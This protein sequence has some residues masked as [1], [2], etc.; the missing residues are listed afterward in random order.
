MFDLKDL[1]SDCSDSELNT[2]CLLFTMMEVLKDKGILSEKEIV[3]ISTI[4]AKLAVD[5]IE[6]K[7]ENW[8][9]SYK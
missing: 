5:L 8:E 7:K 4:G 2:Y 9:K 6:K 3:M 1:V